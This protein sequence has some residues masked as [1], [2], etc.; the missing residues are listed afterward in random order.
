MQGGQAAVAGKRDKD[1]TQMLHAPSLVLVNAGLIRQVKMLAINI[2]KEKGYRHCSVCT[3][4]KS[5]D[6]ACNIYLIAALVPRIAISP[7]SYIN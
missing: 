7:I 2:S 4:P 6:S 5:M 3:F 1:C